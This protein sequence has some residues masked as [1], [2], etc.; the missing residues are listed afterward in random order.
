MH[1]LARYINENYQQRFP[2]DK[3]YTDSM[4][5]KLSKYKG[6]ESIKELFNLDAEGHK[7]F[8]KQ[9]QVNEELGLWLNLEN[10]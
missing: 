5:K 7:L 3:S 2:Q 10:Q 9:I 4:E 6:M 8:A 1:Y